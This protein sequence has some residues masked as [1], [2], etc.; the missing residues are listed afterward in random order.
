MKRRENITSLA[1]VKKI[2]SYTKLPDSDANAVPKK[3]YAVRSDVNGRTT[4]RMDRFA[5]GCVARASPPL[6]V[7]VFMASITY[8]ACACMRNS[9]N[10]S[11]ETSKNRRRRMPRRV[12]AN[13]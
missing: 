1:E 6:S 5:A 9:G 10:P 13:R 12:N 3:S 4:V 2:R 7:F 8:Y 11:H